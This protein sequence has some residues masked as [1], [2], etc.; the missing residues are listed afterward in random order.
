MKILNKIWC[1]L[2][3]H[4][5]QKEKDLCI[6]GSLYRCCHC[7][8]RI[9]IHHARQLVVDWDDEMEALEIDMVKTIARFS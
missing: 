3:N 8:K 2:T 1:F 6:G 9:A 4:T 7:E 5:L